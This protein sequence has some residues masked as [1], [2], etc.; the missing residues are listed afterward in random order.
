MVGHQ[1]LIEQVARFVRV[2]L[3]AN[4][5]AYPPRGPDSPPPICPVSGIAR[6]G[7]FLGNPRAAAVCPTTALRAS[8][9]RVW[10]PS[11]CHHLVHVPLDEIGGGILMGRVRTG[12]IGAGEHA[13][14]V[15]AD[16]PAWRS[17]G[18]SCRLSCPCVSLGS[19]ALL[20]RRVVE[21]VAPPAVSLGAVQEVAPGDYPARSQIRIRISHVHLGAEIVNT[22]SPARRHP[23][24]RLRTSA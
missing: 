2:V 16:N 24:R 18:G 21:I 8:S 19:W 12:T 4:R 10:P 17:R 9:R 6:A 11:R 7:R 14:V 15:V 5:V 1:A 20:D 22:A 13:P 3:R 23:P